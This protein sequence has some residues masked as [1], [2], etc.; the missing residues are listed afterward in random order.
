MSIIPYQQGF[1]TLKITSFL[2]LILGFWVKAKINTYEKNYERAESIYKYYAVMFVWT[3]TQPWCRKKKVR[4]V[5]KSSEKKLAENIC[6]S[7]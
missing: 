1:N 4:H 7:L 3:L 6:L 2:L 5:N